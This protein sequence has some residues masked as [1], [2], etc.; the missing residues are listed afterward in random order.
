MKEIIF[1]TPNLANGGAERVT[2]VLASELA[3]RGNRVILAYMKDSNQIY[4]TEDLIQTHFLFPCRRRTLYYTAGKIWKLRNLIREHPQ[5]SVVAMLP[6]ETLYTFLAGFGQR[7]KIIYSL[8]NDPAHMEGKLE[9]FIKNVIYPTAGTIV[10]QTQEAKAFF[11]IKMR[12]NGIVIPNPIRQD[13]PMRFKGKRKKEIV[14]VGRLAVQKNYPLLLSAFAKIHKD[15]P[16]WKLK[17]YGEGSLK[18]SL[19]HLCGKFLIKEAVEF[20]GFVPDVAEKINKSGMFV[21]SSDYEGISNAM[22]EALGSGVPCICTDCP[23]GGARTFIQHNKNGLLIP[24]GDCG[25][26]VTAMKKLINTPDFAE[27]LSYEAVKIRQKL[28]VSVIA[29]EWEKIL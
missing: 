8:R 22:L 10:F 19:E 5:A 27:Q 2:A 9:K 21:M 17:I 1:V 11:G 28:S 13:L 3:K 6:Y 25:A 23:T 16:E 20:C 4:G 14:A 12:N 26:M 7:R 29:D 15:Y 24:V 18:T